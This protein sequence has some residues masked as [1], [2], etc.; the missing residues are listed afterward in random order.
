MGS[1]ATVTAEL[2]VA[3]RPEVVTVSSYDIMDKRIEGLEAKQ[4]EMLHVQ[5]AR[6]RACSIQASMRTH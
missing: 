1:L 2:I 5:R 6:I 4:K 3:V